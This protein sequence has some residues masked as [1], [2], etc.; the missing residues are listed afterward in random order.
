MVFGRSIK[1]VDFQSLDSKPSHLFFLVLSPKDVSGPHIQ[2]LAVISRNIKDAT[3]R[4]NI[5]QAKTV[6]EIA[7]I[8][9]EFK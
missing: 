2:A 1:G 6:E 7:D 8:I 5:I 3:V 4:E 9:K